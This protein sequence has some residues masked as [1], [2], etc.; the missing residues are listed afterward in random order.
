MPASNIGDSETGPALAW[1]PSKS[2][3]P[4]YGTLDSMPHR[5]RRAGFDGFTWG[6]HR[7]AHTQLT[8]YSFMT[9]YK[10]NGILSSKELMNSCL[11]RNCRREF[12]RSEMLPFW[13]GSK[14]EMSIE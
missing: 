8:R 2:W 12:T 9:M 1:C 13:G 11:P 7:I 3:L 6:E 4:I 10:T 5:G 14:S